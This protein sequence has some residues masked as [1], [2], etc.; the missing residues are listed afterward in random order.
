VH[1]N[2]TRDFATLATFIKRGSRWRAQVRK[3]GQ[4]ALSKAFA[5]KREAEIWARD[6]EQQIDRGLS[7]DAGRR[8]TFGELVAAYREQV[9]RSK[10]MSRSKAQAL[11]RLGKL[12]G[13]RRLVELK[14]VTFLDFCIVAAEA[15][16]GGGAKRSNLEIGKHMGRHDVNSRLE[17]GSHRGHRNLPLWETMRNSRKHKMPS[18]QGV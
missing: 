14:T 13:R 7:I 6:V 5:T 4:P 11:D 2:C 8:V 16:A 10:G 3:F 15:L 9:G 17:T 1:Q 12:L 18:A